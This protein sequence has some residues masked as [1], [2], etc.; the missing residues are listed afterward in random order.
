MSMASFSC[1]INKYGEDMAI[2]WIDS[3]PDMGTGETGYPGYH[4]MVVSA[5]TG[6]GDLELLEDGSEPAPQ[7]QGHQQRTQVASFSTSRA[8][9]LQVPPQVSRRAHS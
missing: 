6:H 7:D 9:H 1:L 4:A 8:R 3:H 5:L 2:V